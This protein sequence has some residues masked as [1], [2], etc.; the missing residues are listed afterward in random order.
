MTSIINRPLFTESLRAVQQIS[1]VFSLAVLPGPWICP[2]RVAPRLQQYC[3]GWW[4]LPSTGFANPPDHA[5]QFY[6][7]YPARSPSDHTGNHNSIDDV[8][9]THHTN[10]NTHTQAKQ[11]V[12]L[13]SSIRIDVRN[14]LIIS[15]N[16]CDLAGQAGELA[17]RP[18][19][20]GSCAIACNG[21]GLPA[22]QG[23]GCNLV[24]HMGI[25]QTPA[26]HVLNTAIGSF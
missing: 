12:Q 9:T 4:P 16:C 18:I 1:M 26:H 6:R 24:Q 15:S 23:C 3:C 8:V 25:A 13:T 2:H 20:S 7:H 10:T 21:S 19:A 5:P 14:M 11:L 17:G 22:H